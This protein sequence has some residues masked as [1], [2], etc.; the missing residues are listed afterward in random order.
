[1]IH[2]LSDLMPEAELAAL[3]DRYGDFPVLTHRV[4]MGPDSLKD[5]RA[6][7]KRRR[8]EILLVLARPTGEVLM[9]TKRFYPQG[10]YRLP[11]G[12]IDWNEPVPDAWQRELWE[13]TQLKCSSERLLGVIGYE[14]VGYS[15]ACGTADE[16]IESVPFVSFVFQQANVVGDPIP[17]DESEQISD[18]QWQSRADL[19]IAAAHLSGLDRIGSDKGDWGRFRAVAH[20]FV[21]DANW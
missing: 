3:R 4:K 20:E 17:L 5:Y 10:V 1:M 12:G 16:G 9:H 8:G 21:H 18:F 19:K 6:Q 15:A 11:T 2:T 7:L 13:E 14:F